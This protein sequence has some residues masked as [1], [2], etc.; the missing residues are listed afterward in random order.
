[1]HALPLGDP[2]KPA[3]G[4]RPA[5]PAP[6]R[7]GDPGL[8]GDES[9]GRLVSRARVNVDP[10]FWMPFLS[11]RPGLGGLIF[12]NASTG[13]RR[14]GEQWW[15]QRGTGSDVVFENGDPPDTQ[16]RPHAR[17]PPHTDI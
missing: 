16:R 1:M 10:V 8:P 4:S 6:P 11:Q 12:H 7:G 3:G 15:D 13:G 17:S 9:V 5:G 2:L 14:N